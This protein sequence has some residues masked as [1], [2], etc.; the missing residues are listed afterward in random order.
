MTGTG[1]AAALRRVQPTRFGAWVVLV[2]LAGVVLLAAAAGRLPSVWGTVDATFL[3]LAALLVAAELRPVSLPRSGGE[4]ESISLSGAFA[5][6]LLL[7]YD[8][9]LVLA[10]HALASVLD[11]G[12]DQVPWWKAGFNVGQY[13]VALAAGAWTMS[14]L[15]H[16]PLGDPDV[17]PPVVVALLACGVFFLLN[18]ALPGIAISLQG[19]T[20]VL[21]SLRDDLPLQWHANGVVIAMAP[22]VVAVANDSLW[23]VAL[24]VAPVVAVHR[25]ARSAFE[26]DHLS[27]HDP[28]TGLPNQVAFRQRLVAQ[29]DEAAHSDRHVAVLVL[30]LD[31]IGDVSNTLG[32]S[33]ADDLLQQVARRLEASVPDGAVLARVQA[34]GF[35]VAV[36]D[37]ES[38]WEA[39]ACAE[40]LL[41]QFS[42]PYAFA[43][44]AFA[45]RASIGLTVAPL[46]GTDPEQLV[47]H[48]EVARDLALR[49]RTGLEVYSADRNAFT[50]RRLAVLRG[51]GPALRRRE[52]TVH[53]QPQADVATGAVLGY[54]ALL[55]WEHPALGTVAPDEFVA[56]AEHA[57]MKREITEF[58]LD[59]SL[60]HL[61][62]WR[63]QGSRATV[64]VNVSAS[65][66]QDLDLPGRVARRLALWGVPSSAL[67]LELTETAVM[68]HP[69][70]CQQVMRELRALQV[71][72]SLDDY[73][74]G[75][76]SL[77]YL[78]T[79]P[80]D[81]LKIDK[82]FV[83]GMVSDPVDR[84]VVRSTVELA[85]QLGL[86]VVAEGVE[87]EESAALLREYGCRVGQGWHYGRPVPPQELVLELDLDRASAVPRPR[88]SSDRPA[89]PRQSDSELEPGQA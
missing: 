86:R 30:A 14:S 78:T 33:A 36:P 4:Q 19:A 84:V 89:C 18:T 9:S 26:R 76:A 40:S 38:P 79:L 1:L 46:H 70:R 80:V 23:L 34:G 71:G 57:G 60:H 73:G 10:I 39:N 72:L 43:E 61:A 56:L 16:G 51:L 42:A 20:P 63:R 69:Q 35:V 8:W 49:S 45:L 82:R 81:E 15:G 54:E 67:V 22:L 32:P 52:M 64:S 74:T 87:D 50:E 31:H 5:C 27:L 37:L 11:D 6:A 77:A 65:V 29:L 44:S 68:S 2:L 58:V 41:Q 88:S 28:L 62:D 53:F 75:Y 66:L 85:G 24:L 55:R 83:L 25:G 7:H 59:E 21:R 48:A 12:R 17:V 3:L 13:S 47:Q